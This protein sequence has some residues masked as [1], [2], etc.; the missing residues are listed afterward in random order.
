MARRP[1]LSK[2][3]SVSSPAA[4]P[5]N[6][7]PGIPVRLAALLAMAWLVL[8]AGG[9]LVHP[10]SADAE[11]RRFDVL[12]LLPELLADHFT[13][14]EGDLPG[15]WRFLPQRFDIV[16]TA[17]FLVAGIWGLGRL[18][19]RAVLFKG[20]FSAGSRLERTA[21]TFGL[22]AAAW[23][24]LTL[25]FGLAGW[26][27]RPLFIGV[28]FVALAAEL[29]W[30]VATR[31][32]HQATAGRV[33]HRPD[34]L[35]IGIAAI[36]VLPF[37]LAAIL[38]STLPPFDF[39]V[40]EYHLGG[41]KEWFQDGRVHFLPHNVYTS[42]PALTEMLSLSAMVVRGDW[43]RGALAGQLL[44]AG[45]L[46][47]TAAA[48]FA[49]GRR[50]FNP[51]AGLIGAVVY[52]TTP[53]VYRISTVAYAEG[54]VTCYLA[55]ALLGFVLVVA[56]RGT[57]GVYS[58]VVLT[59]LFA[60]SAMACKYPG[61]IQVVIPIG[62]ACAAS[63]FAAQQRRPGAP[64]RG[65]QWTMTVAAYGTGVV[66]AVGPWLIKNT[67]ETGNPVYPLLGSLIDSRDWDAELNAKW[68][69]AHSPPGFA[70]AAFFTDLRYIAVGSDGQSLLVFGLAPLALLGSRRRAA[71]WL[72]VY[73]AFLYVAWWALTHRI[74]RFWIPLLPVASLLAGAGATWMAGLVA[75][76]ATELAITP[77]RRFWKPVCVATFVVALLYNA[78]F[79]RPPQPAGTGF[80]ADLEAATQAATTPAIAELNATLPEDVL[81]LLVGEAEI[82]DA[83]FP[84]VYNTVF[85]RNLF[86]EWTAEPVRGSFREARKLR[87]AGEIRRSLASRGVTHLFVNWREILRYRTTYGFTPFVTPDRFTALQQNGVLGESQTL[88]TIPLETLPE[89]QRR[90]AEREFPSLIR[91]VGDG[92]MLT[93][94]E[95]F[96][97][98]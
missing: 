32:P 66:L 29:L 43:F 50:L 44:L 57:R 39:D 98:Q 87:S 58:S 28:L 72:W 2:P 61:V 45:F 49:T 54:G 15:G 60:G 67:I 40:K 19:L 26:L 86:E 20:A 24:L 41:P 74:D 91:G 31:E 33:S 36:A 22:G 89:T 64:G 16:V 8:F 81:V 80:L 90:E 34:A 7:R 18:V 10:V 13:A 97:V 21:F 83:R 59:G 17:L 77:E 93:A 73:V 48:V 6:P 3:P 23:S 37:V 52:V 88:R 63:L 38:G 35:L 69:A 47:L 25:M 71:A 70:P 94:G 30:I 46:P 56:Q 78:V 9:F 53:W 1:R 5:E 14:G 55:L 84:L 42:F 62:V 68:R 27:S 51:T 4:V 85:D 12:L 79:L 95:L 11:L 92:R 75:D 96:P 82:F 76:S 65:R